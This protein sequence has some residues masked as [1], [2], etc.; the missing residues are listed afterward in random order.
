MSNTDRWVE[1]SIR[2]VKFVVPKDVGMKLFDAL[3]DG[4]N[5]YRREYDWSSK[6]EWVELFNS[7]DINISIMPADR[8][9]IMKLVGANKVLERQQERDNAK[10]A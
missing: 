4:D 2:G 5:I 10:A 1:L 8:M 7:E 6:M 9:A 3:V